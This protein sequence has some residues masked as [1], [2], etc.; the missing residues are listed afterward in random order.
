M[1][2]DV[3]VLWL[4]GM[5]GAGKSAVGRGLA[6]K[7]GLPFIDIDA[8]IAER[9][10]RSIAELWTDKGEAAFRDLESA[11]VKLIAERAAHG[12]TAVVATGGGV[13]LDETN[14]E[15]MQSHGIVVWLTAPPAVLAERVGDG[16]GRPLLHEGDALATLESLLAARRHHYEAA[17]NVVIDTEGRDVDQTIERVEAAWIPS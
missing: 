1:E 6:R 11:V 10:G 5:M 13:V 8:E 17:A 16:R 3:P 15:L 9:T 14:R 4:V 7:H 12:E 2:R